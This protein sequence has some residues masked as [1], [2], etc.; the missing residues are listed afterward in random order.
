[1][2]QW[3]IGS[4]SSYIYVCNI[5]KHESNNGPANSGEWTLQEAKHGSKNSSGVV[6]Y[7]VVSIA[8]PKSNVGAICVARENNEQNPFNKNGVIYSTYV[9]YQH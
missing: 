2:G 7:P 1:M 8:Q 5:W 9:D 4:T 3:R 6:P